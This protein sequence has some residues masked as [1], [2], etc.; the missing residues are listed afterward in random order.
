ML[1][2]LVQAGGAACHAA[3]EQLH[4]F[5]E[6]FKLQKYEMFFTCHLRQAGSTLHL[7]QRPVVSL[8]RINCN[9]S[10]DD[11]VRRLFC[12]FSLLPWC[13]QRVTV[14]PWV[15]TTICRQWQTLSGVIIGEM[16]SGFLKNSTWLQK[17]TVAMEL[18]WTEHNKTGA[19]TLWTA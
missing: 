12:G 7:L 11:C 13:H 10:P 1:A 2:C 19:E 18:Q 8:H 14:S 5:A 16:T 15:L 3:R 6:P 17:Q 4:V 9:P